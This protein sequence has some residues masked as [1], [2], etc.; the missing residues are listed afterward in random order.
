MSIRRMQAAIDVYA[1]V[2]EG[3]PARN[4][5]KR[6]VSFLPARARVWVFS[7]RFLV[8]ALWGGG[9][10]PC[11][12]GRNLSTDPHAK[13]LWHKEK[14]QMG[15][16]RQDP[17]GDGQRGGRVGL[18]ARSQAADTLRARMT[19][20]FCNVALPLPLR[21][22][23]TY[24]VPGALSGSIQPGS[25]VLVPFRKKSLIGVVVEGVESAPEGP[26]VREIAKV[27]E[28]APALTPRLIELAQWI[29]G[30]YLAPIG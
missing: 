29:A 6:R 23:F 16:E 18:D 20:P 2:R 8:S 17:G 27:M 25:R 10:S 1:A 14:S 22:T 15:A 13:C 26:R 7:S 11:A 28:A 9:R 21:T 4:L 5:L 19:S 24:A 3:P 12:M 30:Y